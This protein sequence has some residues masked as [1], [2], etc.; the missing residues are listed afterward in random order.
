MCM[1][2]AVHVL[3]TV[4]SNCVSRSINKT[5]VTV[6]CYTIK[7]LFIM[8]VFYTVI[9]LEMHALQILFKNI[10]NAIKK[11]CSIICEVYYLIPWILNTGHTILFT[12][13]NTF[14]MSYWINWEMHFFLVIDKT[15]DIYYNYSYTLTTFLD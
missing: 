14:N 4:W 7:S 6:F 3:W 10:S 12:I 11:M 8:H 15:Y 9:V 1:P 5:Q 13:Y 2:L